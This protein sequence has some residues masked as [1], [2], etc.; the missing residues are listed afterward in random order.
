MALVQTSLELPLTCAAMQKHVLIAKA[1]YKLS[2]L[3]TTS[4]MPSLRESEDFMSS[5]IPPSENDTVN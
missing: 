1:K 3:S 4:L 2:L 5:E